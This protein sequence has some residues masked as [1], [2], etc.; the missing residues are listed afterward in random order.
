MKSL[1]RQYARG[2]NRKMP[3]LTSMVDR[4]RRLRLLDV[5]YNRDD[6]LIAII[7]L[8]SIYGLFRISELLNEP[9]FWVEEVKGR[10]QLHVRLTDSKTL[11]R[12]DGQPE[13]V[14]VSEVEKAGPDVWCP[15]NLVLQ[16]VFRQK[17]EK[18]QMSIPV[19]MNNGRKLTRRIYSQK[20]K[21]L[22]NK[23]GID[24][25]QY[26]TH[27]GRIGGATMMW[28]AGYSD[29][30]IKRFGRWR[31]E[32]WTIYCRTLKSKFIDLARTLRDS[33][34]RENDIVFNTKE[35]IVEMRGKKE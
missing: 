4:F 24:S 9:T 20:L 18:R 23:I 27:S 28:E 12:N 30:Q 7:M 13:I 25:T 15:V 5:S 2:V 33:K 3:L 14:V 10:R 21:Q 19:T 17:K 29:A 34:V 22:L 1:R 35:L 8:L 32:S 6:E 11:W 26:D 16:R 31:S